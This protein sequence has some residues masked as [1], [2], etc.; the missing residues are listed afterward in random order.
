MKVLVTGGMGYIGS[1]S[2]KALL[3]AGHQVI[4]FDNLSSGHQIE[5]SA[6]LFKGDLTQL[7]DIEKVCASTEFDAVMHL[8]G[9]IEVSESQTNPDCYYENNV[10]GTIN[11]LHAIH[12]YK[13]KTLVFSSTAAVYADSE[14]SP[15]KEDAQVHPINTYS[16]SKLMVEQMLNDYHNAYGLKVVIFRY[17]NA[18]G[19]STDASMGESH[20]PESHLIPI[21]IQKMLT[22]QVFKINGNDFTT[23]DG[24]A[25]RDFVHVMD[26]AKA[27]VLGLEYAEF[28]NRYDIFNI[29]S[30]KGYSILEV[31]KALQEITGTEIQ[32]E[33]GPRRTGESAML[34]AAIDKA[35]Q[36]LAWKP[37]YSSLQT[38]LQ[39]ALHWHKRESFK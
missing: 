25:I 4:I 12:K 37:E 10:L 27:H 1:Q 23:P 2:V 22:K 6:H 31:V 13:I 33:F 14:K 8:A 3:N 39:T 9:K 29:G 20:T 17:F 28:E 21:L 36:V 30:G 38:I 18:A 26:I 34:T 15:L 16:R 19:A 35:S 24:T 5:S 7:A 32:T 11:L